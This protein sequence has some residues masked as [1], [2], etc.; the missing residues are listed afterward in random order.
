[1]KN[2]LRFLF[3]NWGLKLLALVLAL[4]IYHSLSDS[5]QNQTNDRTFFK[6]H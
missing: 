3:G 6:K 1:M 5:R 4:I 2:I